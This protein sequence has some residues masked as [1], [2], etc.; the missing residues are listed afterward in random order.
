MCWVLGHNHLVKLPSPPLGRNK[1]E[2]LWWCS[3]NERGW[4]HAQLFISHTELSNYHLATWFTYIVKS[5]IY[6]NRGKK[7]ICITVTCS[8]W[9]VI[10][11]GRYLI[12]F[13]E[14]KLLYSITEPIYLANVVVVDVTY[15]LNVTLIP[16]GAKRCVWLD[17]WITFGAPSDH[18][19]FGGIVYIWSMTCNW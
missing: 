8:H 7:E 10:H 3:H 11:G 19:S 12:S 16:K 1:N 13:Y 18:W 17:A 14:K 5:I 2:N 9:I 15:K 6:R 4:G